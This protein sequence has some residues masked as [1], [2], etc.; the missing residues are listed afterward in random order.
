MSGCIYQLLQHPETIP[1]EFTSARNEFNRFSEANDGYGVLYSLI[2]PFLHKDTVATA[3]TM[4]DCHDIH[5]YAQKV[6]SYFHCKGITERMYNEKEKATIFLNGLDRR[7]TRQVDPANSLFEAC[8][9][10]ITGLVPEILLPEKIPDTID[11]WW[12]DKNGQDVIR[13]MHLQPQ[14]QST[15]PASSDATQKLALEDNKKPCKICQIPGHHKSEC[16]GY[17]KHILFMEAD[18]KID[19][20]G[21][22]KIVEK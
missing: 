10:K 13:T 3:P 18:Q 9:R 6:T 19:D 20:K 8:N 4:N 1:L 11:G 17:A 22:T 5:A 12:K 2:E 16:S 7:Y 21:C 15:K 14:D